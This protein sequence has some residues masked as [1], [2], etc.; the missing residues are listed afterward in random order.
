MR[1][2]IE[3]SR[4]ATGTKKRDIVARMVV[5]AIPYSSHRDCS[6]RTIASDCRPCAKGRAVT[7][8][9]WATSTP[10]VAVESPEQSTIARGLRLIMDS[11]VGERSS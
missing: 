2:G 6:N 1:E 3:A 5:W 10:R 7:R 9:T 4:D 11:I 8:A